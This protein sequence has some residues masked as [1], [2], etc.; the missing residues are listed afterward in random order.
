MQIEHATQENNQ[1]N[2]NCSFSEKGEEIDLIVSIFLCL[3]VADWVH[4]AL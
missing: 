1:N 2:I 4:L 3:G